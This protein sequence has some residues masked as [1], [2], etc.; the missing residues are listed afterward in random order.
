[1]ETA[2]GNGITNRTNKKENGNRGWN[3]EDSIS[4]I[5]QRETEAQKIIIGIWNIKSIAG[6]EVE[7]TEEM[8]KYGVKITNKW[9]KETGA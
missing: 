4:Q 2:N 9:N 7:V 6:K 5:K 3:K 1:M 8:E